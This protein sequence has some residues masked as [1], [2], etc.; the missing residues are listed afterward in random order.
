[1]SCSHLDAHYSQELQIQLKESE[2]ELKEAKR[3]RLERLEQEADKNE[4]C[5]G[6]LGCI[7][8]PKFGGISTGLLLFGLGLGLLC[9]CY[10]STLINKLLCSC[11]PERVKNAAL[12]APEKDDV[13][14][15][16]TIGE[17]DSE[18]EK[19]DLKDDSIDD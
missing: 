2:Q 10:G 1:M 7:N 18:E 12:R 8:L 3:K 17:D 13:D 5:L 11:C 9:G 19:K 4:M 16:I 6:W 15:K 14:I